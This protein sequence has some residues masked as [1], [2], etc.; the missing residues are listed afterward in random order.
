MSNAQAFNRPSL[1][2][3]PWAAQKLLSLLNNI[4]GRIDLVTPNGGHM[5]LG[6]HGKSAH[7]HIKD[8]RV[9]KEV[10]LRSDIGFAQAYIDGYWESDNLPMLLEVLAD[11][12]QAL[13]NIWRRHSLSKW[14]CKCK[15]WFNANTR[16][17]SKRN[18][19]AH[20]DL[21]NDF[22][23]L[24]LDDTLSYSS[25]L[26]T[27]RVT[28]SLAQAQR[29]KY[30]RI[31]NELKP[32]ASQHLL[33]IGCGFG[34]F[35]EVAV[36][37]GQRVYGVTLSKKQWEIA[38]QRVNPERAQFELRDYRDIE[39]QFDHIVSIEMFEAVGRQYW[40]TYFAKIKSCLAHDGKAVIQTITIADELFDDYVNDTDFIQQFIFPGG[41]LPSISEFKKMARAN[42]LQII[43][44]HAFGLDYAE[45]LRRWR[46][47]FH[48]EKTGVMQLGFD[49]KFI[50]TWDFYLAYCEAGFETHS[51]DVVQF[52]LAHA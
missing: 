3:L 4:D 39:G 46:A 22:F 18:I 2:Q 5:V 51:T 50:R 27:N 43:N 34:G 16:R 48:K 19:S 33:E 17:G 26:F 31:L 12:R 52:T 45:T 36:E 42:G 49:E 11:N 13:S 24:W 38:T 40:N 21:G 6:N 9:C 35:A 23:S 32:T 14:W 8:W 37:S 10:I 44:E 28:D 41:L 30:E 25:A 15:H 1:E 47:S 20:Y 7:L 29:T